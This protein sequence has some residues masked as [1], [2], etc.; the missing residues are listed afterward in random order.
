LAQ[1]E[2]VIAPCQQ[3]LAADP[4][5]WQAHF[6]LAAAYGWL[7]RDAEAKAEVAEMM[8]F[9]AGV[10]RVLSYERDLSDNPVFLQQMARAAQGW[11]KAGM[12]EEFER[13]DEVQSNGR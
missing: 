8:K 6:D 1:W 9:G 11:R 4:K 2:Q 5:L 13:A 7:G 12:P 10:K 3:A